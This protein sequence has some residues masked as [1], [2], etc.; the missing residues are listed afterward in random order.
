MPG[1]ET[2]REAVRKVLSGGRASFL[3]FIPWVCIHAAKLQQVPLRD[4]LNDPSLLTRALEN[5]QRL[6]GYDMVV[7]IF[8]TTI[9]AEAC[10]CPVKW[11]NDRELP[12]VET[13]STIDHLSEGDIS[14]IMNKGRLPVVIETT[15][16]LKITLGRTVA[17][18]GVVTG[19]FTLASHLKGQ[20]I[21]VALND[22]PETAEGVVEL[23]GKVCLEVC[24]SYCELEVDVIVLADSV[25][26]QLSERHFPLA[27]SALGPMVNVIRFYDGLSLLLASGCTLDSLGLLSNLETDG[28][29]VDG[30]VEAE[31]GQGGS[32]SIVG[33]TIPSS[34][35]E[36][37]KE[38][39]I[40]HID[41]SLKEGHFLSTEWQVPY[42]TPPENIH[43]LMKYIKEV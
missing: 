38:P 20:N 6:Y 1:S 34:L 10:G 43:H 30:S 37:P 36:G 13:H 24:K 40:A 22:N 15:K 29:V 27:L 8:D 31:L 28:M 12:V 2:S 35:I 39:L 3:P 4:M 25:M 18:A 14:N 21:A 42:D 26:P 41:H 16:R 11:G 19:P 17:I 5:A 33:Q 32:R 7:N 23:A 9:E